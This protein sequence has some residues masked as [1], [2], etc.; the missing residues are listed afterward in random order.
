M[1]AENP[2]KS[3]E[4]PGNIVIDL[5]FVK[6]DIGVPVHSRDEEEIDD[7]A[8]EKQPQGEKV[9]GTGNRLAIIKA[10]GAE[11]AENPEEVADED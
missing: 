7:P 5:A 10:M 9:E 6:A 4:Q 3:E 1:D 2:E 8:D 11:E